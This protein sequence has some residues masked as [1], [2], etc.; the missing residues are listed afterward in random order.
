MAVWGCAPTWLADKE[1]C[2]QSLQ[3]LQVYFSSQRLL[4]KLSPPPCLSF[5]KQKAE[6]QP[7]GFLGCHLQDQCDGSNLLKGYSNGAGLFQTLL[8]KIRIKNNELL[9]SQHSQNTVNCHYN[10]ACSVVL[11][12]RRPTILTV[13]KSTLSKYFPDLI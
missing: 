11:A 7:G 4:S 5:Q 3:F 13:G 9:N 8:F 12:G 6:S 1:I 10:Y 2:F